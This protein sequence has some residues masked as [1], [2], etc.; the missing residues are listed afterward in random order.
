MALADLTW[1]RL[2]DQIPADNA[3][4]TVLTSIKTA[5]ESVVD[6]HGAARTPGT[7]RAWSVGLTEGTPLEAFSLH[8]PSGS[9]CNAVVVVA[10]YNGAKTPQMASPD[11]WLAN[12]ILALVSSNGGTLAT[13]DGVT[14][15]G[16]SARIT[17]FTRISAA[18]TGGTM[19][20]VRCYEC[21]EAIAIILQIGTSYY[22]V[23]IGALWDPMSADAL[24]AE[25]DGR[26]YGFI[27]SSS[28]AILATFDSTAS[29]GTFSA[30]YSP[31]VGYGH[32]NY[33]S[34][35]TSTLLTAH[36][37]HNRRAGTVATSYKK[38]SGKWSRAPIWY[39]EAVTDD[40]IGELRG[41][42]RGPQSRLGR[43]I[44]TGGAISAH[45]VGGSD[46]ADCDCLQLRYV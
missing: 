21:T 15:L 44:Y 45:A 18:T 30:T 17:K 5:F 36:R 19:G 41:I 16:A 43:T 4:S 33:L 46:S 32:I 7:G 3:A 29:A 8:P 6:F 34:P 42:R 2:P 39:L 14:P 26:L 11:T 22:G 13:W 37:A 40:D 31:S 24:D 25:A 9:G 38:P 23:I 20:E 35:G 1:R 27:T 10:G 28:S 12:A